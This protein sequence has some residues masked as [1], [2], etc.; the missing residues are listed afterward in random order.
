MSRPRSLRKEI[1]VSYSVILLLALTIFAG[2]AYAILRTSLQRAGTQSLRQTAYA[3]EQLIAP[4]GIPR[5]ATR[6]VRLPPGPGQVEAM[7]RSTRLAT[8]EELNVYVARTGDVEGHALHSFALIA[9]FLIPLTAL[10]AAL[11]GRTVAD[12]TLQPLERL[13]A[14][15]REIGIAGLARRVDVP[16]N[17]TELRELGQSFNEMLSRL[18]RAVEAL[19]RF[20]ADASHELRTPLTA[21]RGSLQVALARPREREELRETLEEVLDETSAMLALVEDLLTLARGDESAARAPETTVDLNAVLR[22]VQDI[23]QALADGRPLRVELDAP[24]E[25]RVRGSAGG[26]RRLFL[27][28]VS[29][30]VKFTEQGEVVISARPADGA[31]DG[32]WIEVTVRDTGPG[33]AAEDLPRVFDRFYRADE[34][35]ES[36]SG[37]GL[38]LAIARMIATHHGG[39]ITAR[40]TVGAGSEF[41]VRLP[42]GPELLEA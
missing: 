24:A 16:D 30:A 11:V 27:N 13:V 2:I 21:I 19:R 32:R 17:P 28:L 39:T 23:G 12:R 5:I 7:R 34:A 33:I 38:G 9:F 25:L 14:A 8:G 40:S 20:T 18:E 15:S 42:A 35:R 26:L 41:V 6:E 4:P 1:V 36:G 29:N 31:E 3:A 22:D 37:S 10:A